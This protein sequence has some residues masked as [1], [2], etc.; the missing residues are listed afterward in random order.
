MHILLTDRLACPRCGPDFGLILLADRVEDRRVHD[1]V[2]GCANCRDRFP[3][4]DGFG[5][6]RA[7][8]RGA[9]PEAAPPGDAAGPDPVKLAALLGVHEGPGHVALVGDVARSAGGLA[10]LL[11]GIEVVAVWSEAR[12]WEEG[13][14]VSRIAARPGLPFFSRVLRGVVLGGS[15]AQT[16]LDEAVRVVA[17]SARV[18]VLDPPAGSLRRLEEAGLSAVLDDPRVVVAT[19]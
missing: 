3:V 19:R 10:D 8:P 17:A 11:D 14:G 7:P 5:D 18:A 6:L 9:F 1:G 16:W 15:M 13:E 4:R 12:R 2:L